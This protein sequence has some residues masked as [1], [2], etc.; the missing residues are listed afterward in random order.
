MAGAQVLEAPDVIHPR[1]I[2]L[3]Q[4]QGRGKIIIRQRS[5]GPRQSLWR[6]RTGLHGG[7]R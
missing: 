5:L 1:C 4:A 2:S 6:A 7:L 3:W